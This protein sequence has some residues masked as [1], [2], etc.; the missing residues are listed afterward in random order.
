MK[1]PQCEFENR[2]G[3]KFCE[4]CGAKMP[5]ICPSCGSEIGAGA[6][7]CG[8]C[9]AQIDRDAPAT[10]PESTQP[11]K[12]EDMHTQLQR[13]IPKTLAQKIYLAEQEIEGENRLVTALF[14]DISGF[15]PMSQQLSPEA[16]VEKVN[17][18]FQIITDAVYRYEGN[19]NRFIGDCVLAFFGAP[20]THEND[21]ERAILAALDMRE[22]VVH[23][24]LNIS[25]GINTGMAYFG[26]IGTERHPEVSAYGHDINLAKR[27]QEAAGPGQIFIGAGTYRLSRRTFDFNQLGE[28]A[29]KGMESPVPIY[30]V[31]NIKE[32]PEKLR[33]IEG[34][35]ARMIGREREFS[36]LKEA[37]DS[38]ISGRGGIV[39]VIGEAGLGKSRLALELREY[40]KDKGVTQYEGRSISIGQTVSYW[41]FMDIL[42]AYLGLGDASSEVEVAGKLKESMMELFPNRWED[43]LPFLG[44]LLSIKFGD[45][46]DD[47]LSY[48]TPE[49]VRHQTLMRLRDIFIAISR[50]EPLLLILED[51]HWADD[52]SL[53]LISLLMDELTANPL[54]LLC[55][56]RPEREHRCWQIGD[57]ASRKCLESYTE[58]R[59]RK[60]STV[61]GRELVESLLT[62][63]NLPK[64]TKDMILR[65]SE[66]NPFFIEEVIRF[67]IDGDL[68]YREDDRWKARDGIGDIDVP[69]TIQSVLLSR[70]DRLEGETRYIL[71]CASVIG[72]LFRYRL[73]KHLSQHEQDLE[74]HLSQLE[75]RDLVYEER[76]VPELEYAFKHALTQ[77][78][79]YQGILERQRREFH[80]RIADGIEA[81]YQE[82]IE[83]FYE[84]LAHHHK[85]GGNEEKAIEYLLKSGVKAAGNFLN[86]DALR[87]LNQ[88]EELL[89]KST[90]PHRKEK[91]MLYEKRGEV[92]QWIGRWIEA[93]KGYEEALQWCD[94]PHDRA[95]I[96]QKIGWLECEEIQDKMSA[97]EHMKLGLE[98]L[99]EDD[100]S[101]QRVRLEHDIA[102]ASA[103][104]GDSVENML[105]RCQQAAKISEE[106]GY[107]REL[108]ILRAAIERWQSSLGNYSDEH[109]Q[110]AIAVAEEL[111]DLPTLA[112]IYWTMGGMN[113]CIRRGRQWTQQSIRY[114]LLAA[115]IS[116]RIGDIQTQATTWS[117]LG[118]AYRELGQDERAMESWEKALDIAIGTRSVLPLLFS[119]EVM[120]VYGRRGREDMVISTFSRIM[121]AFVSLEIDEE[122]Q[123]WALFRGTG[124]DD[125]YTVYR[126]FRESYCSMGRES[127]FSNI[128]REVLTDL[129]RNVNSRPQRAWYH[130]QL[131]DVNLELGDV[132]SANNHA[133]EVVSIVEEMGQADCMTRLYPAYLLLGDVCAANGLAYRFLGNLYTR[134]FSETELTYRRFGQAE[135]FE[136]LCERIERERG[137]E[138]SDAGVNQI[139]LKPVRYPEDFPRTEFVDG[140]ESGSL[141]PSWEWLDPEGISSYALHHDPNCLEISAAG[142]SELGYGFHNAPGLSQPI[143]GDFAIETRMGGDKSGGLLVSKDENIITLQ[144]RLHWRGSGRIMLTD[145][146]IAADGGSL[147]AESLILRLERKDDMLRAYCSG[148]GQNWYICGWIEIEM[149]DPVQV[150]IFGSC[151][152]GTPQAVTSFDYVKIFREL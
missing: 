10:T 100:M 27:M 52:L 125:I 115:E 143:S 7:F 96:Y 102:W 126:V 70:V 28:T 127:E 67:L 148:D 44:H 16:T 83:D 68:V 150:G 49:Q 3:V 101:V 19:I 113:L 111:G 114:L 38:L 57:I 86:Q 65:K 66:G 144:R 145:R 85:L 79:T 63:D 117:L 152:E 62:I 9:G 149:E 139:C 31:L 98:E 136:R 23:L 75:Q 26:S 11:P 131:M 51:L 103:G 14:A 128:A 137:K 20:L 40:L 92:L 138:L 60:L 147:D 25:V 69:D 45:E 76:T 80:Q 151:P 15:T 74:D 122:Y 41:P 2:E 58:I 130:T 54:M 6:K 56:Y 21:T 90:E 107:R 112:W 81:L 116:E 42:R 88:A 73:L 124:R 91:A 118:L 121:G 47:R 146:A 55:I 34:L 72:R 94:G 78:S 105:L 120:E 1:C 97:I 30:E 141:S 35:R 110:K 50:S 33:G 5:S 134:K 36:D 142:G 17:Q 22:A 133:K 99:P 12:L 53:D 89:E 39:S 59:L 61:Q 84:E 13:F 43:V 132:C 71:Q 93:I 8:E 119:S 24:G 48:F 32:R 108:A 87:Y 77:E 109:G 135:A 140:F 123:A 46:L 37:A 104:G 64:A 95:E 106:M 18:C 29:I 4:E 82:R 129:L